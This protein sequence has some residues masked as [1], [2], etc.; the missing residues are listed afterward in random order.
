MPLL[1]QHYPD[2]PPF[3]ILDLA[4]A[5]GEAKKKAEK[6]AANTTPGDSTRAKAGTSP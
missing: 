5:P 3:R 1:R 4:V 2:R 6:I